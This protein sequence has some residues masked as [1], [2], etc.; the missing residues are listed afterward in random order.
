MKLKFE[1]KYS[2]GK[3]WQLDT[4]E[5]GEYE[6]EITS[7]DF[8]NKLAYGY[9]F[10]VAVKE[11]IS[12][13]KWKACSQMTHTIQAQIPLVLELLKTNYEVNVLTPGLDVIFFKG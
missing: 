8:I 4:D 1:I 13:R 10:S 3:F 12:S 7:F 6:T 5:Y 9:R 2:E 11:K